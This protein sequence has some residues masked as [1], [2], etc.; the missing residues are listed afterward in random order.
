MIAPVQTISRLTETE[1]AGDSLN[2]IAIFSALGLL[3]S[4]LY[5]TCGLDLSPAF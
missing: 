2:I 4:L 3:V 1:A 5:L